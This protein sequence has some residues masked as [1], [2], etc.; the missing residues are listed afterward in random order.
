MNLLQFWYAKKCN[1]Y[2][3]QSSINIDVDLVRFVTLITISMP[4]CVVVKWKENY[5]IL[6]F[7]ILI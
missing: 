7:F 4:S 3:R 1:I 5:D 6:I 2:L